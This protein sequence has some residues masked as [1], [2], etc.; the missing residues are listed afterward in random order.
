MGYSSCLHASYFIVSD[1]FAPYEPV[2]LQSS[3]HWILRAKY[4]SRLP[5]HSSGGLPDERDRSVSPVLKADSLSLSLTCG[6][7]DYIREVTKSQN[8]TD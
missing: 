2:T 1:S 8:L 4:R 3:V 6:K 5:F 7:L